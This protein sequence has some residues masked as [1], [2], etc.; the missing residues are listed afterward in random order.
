MSLTYLDLFVKSAQFSQQWLYVKNTEVLRMIV[1]AFL[2][3][4]RSSDPVFWLY[5]R[6]LQRWGHL[7]VPLQNS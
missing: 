3:L 6:W 1:S 4:L 7:R 5:K 2:Q